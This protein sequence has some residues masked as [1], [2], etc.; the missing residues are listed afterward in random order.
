MQ[1]ILTFPLRAPKW[2][3]GHVSVRKLVQSYDVDMLT[4]GTIVS[5]NYG[6]TCFVPGMH[7]A[8]AWCALV[9]F[10]FA[11]FTWFPWIVWIVQVSVSKCK[12][13]FQAIC[14][15][16]FCRS[17]YRNLTELCTTSSAYCGGLRMKHTTLHV[18]RNKLLEHT[19]NL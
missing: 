7:V 11:W 16:T 3:Q 17:F 1:K 14:F 8:R 12:Y 9:R 19:F 6:G 4:C 2:R 18:A 10:Q 5:T 15:H 13:F